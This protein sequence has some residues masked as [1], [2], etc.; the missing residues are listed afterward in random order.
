MGP[1]AIIAGIG[2]A[3]SAGSA[4][5]SYKAQKKQVK[6]QK[7][8]AA[9]QRAQDNMKAARDRREAIRTARISSATVQQ[10]AA[11]QGVSNSSAALGG[12]G[13]IQSQ[14]NQGLSFLDGYNTLSDQAGRDL[15][16]ANK[17]AMQSQTWDKVGAFGQK[18]FSSAGQFGGGGGGG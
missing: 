4:I 6:Y 16:K 2:L 1:L 17:F 18:I 11:N 3:I 14:L 9:A 12:E 13:S 5:M 10:N 8:A 7:R 15:T